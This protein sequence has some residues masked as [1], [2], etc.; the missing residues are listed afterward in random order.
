MTDTKNDDFNIADADRHQLKF[1]AKE[2]YDLTL[3]MSMTEDTMRDRIVEHCKKQGIDEPVATLAKKGSVKN[4]DDW[5]TVNVA[6]QDKKGGAEPAFVGFQGTGYTIPRG[7]NISV[8][9][10][11]VEVLKNA[12]QEIVTQDPDTGELH[13]EEVLTYPFQLVSGGN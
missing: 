7:I 10:G 13:S 6:K 11:V 2:K 9:P 4:R 5:L 8:P 1:H 3:S 12:M